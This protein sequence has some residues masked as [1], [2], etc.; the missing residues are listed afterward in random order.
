MEAAPRREGVK[1]VSEPSMELVRG[2]RRGGGW[3]SEIFDG[4]LQVVHVGLVP[5]G[6]GGGSFIRWL[7]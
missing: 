7:G 4:P 3:D 1:G 6:S 2:G 5:H